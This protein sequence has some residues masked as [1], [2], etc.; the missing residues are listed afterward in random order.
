MANAILLL[1]R[2]LLVSMM[3]SVVKGIIKLALGSVDM[4]LK[5]KV[6]ST[7]NKYDDEAYKVFSDNKTGIL[8][9]L[10]R[11]IYLISGNK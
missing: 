9:A 6:E 10:E 2:P 4:W 5:K 8:D 7:D 1:L 11:V 3:F